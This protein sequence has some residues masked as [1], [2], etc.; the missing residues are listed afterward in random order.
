LFCQVAVGL[1]VADEAFAVG[2]EAQSPTDSQAQP[3]NGAEFR[4]LKASRLSY[5]EPAGSLLKL[6]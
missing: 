6:T 3:K 4:A 2:V 1:G 5:S